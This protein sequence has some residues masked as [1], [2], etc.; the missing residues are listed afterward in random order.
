MFANGELAD[1][2]W[3]A[4]KKTDL[5]IGVDGGTKYIRKPDLIIGDLDSLKKV[6]KN[7]PIIKYPRDKDMTD[8]ELALEY[9]LKQKI[10]EVILVGF[11]GRRLD[12]M[13]SNLMVLAK[14]P[15]KV[16]IIEG[17]QEIFYCKNKIEISGKKNDLISLI[18]LLGDCQG[19]MTQGLKWCLQGENLQVGESRGVSNEMLG[20]RCTVGLK[21]GCLL[22]IHTFK[23]VP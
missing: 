14:L 10:E 18:P 13:I 12:H 20:N 7:I 1:V 23:D 15:I 9:C 4:I 19:V 5:L 3:L 2:S 11:L 21:R 22:I 17:N 16:S 6:P 8:M